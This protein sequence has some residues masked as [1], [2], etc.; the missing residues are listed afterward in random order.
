V[1]RDYSLYYVVDLP[2]PAGR[3]PIGLVSEAV[4]GGATAVQLRGEGASGRELYELATALK[5]ALAAGVPL[6][7][8]DRLD[9][10]LAAGADGVHVGA[11]DLPFGRVRELAPGLILGVSCYGDLALAER[12]AAAGADY[13]AFGAFFPSP[14]KRKAAVVPTA[15]LAEAG[16]LGRP[17]VAIGGITLE[18]VEGLVAAGAD[19]VAVIS[20]IQGADDPRAAAAELRAAVDRARGARRA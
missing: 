3:E 8:N 7:V 10:A 16:R 4:A 2:V 13:L 1:E 14:S 17:V 19:G 15:V 11:E 18:R 6:I 9:V 20:A 12:A 5:G